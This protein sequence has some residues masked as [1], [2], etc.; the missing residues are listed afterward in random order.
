MIPFAE[1]VARVV[2]ACDEYGFTVSDTGHGISIEFERGSWYIA[3]EE[4]GV[5]LQGDDEARYCEELENARKM[6]GADDIA[7]TDLQIYAASRSID[8]A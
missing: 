5:F 3:P 6:P 4:N 1:I 7:D 8:Y 2:R